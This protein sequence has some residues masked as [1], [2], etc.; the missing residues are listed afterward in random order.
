MI[1]NTD[2]LEFIGISVSNFRQFKNN[3]MGWKNSIIYHSGRASRLIQRI[4]G[5]TEYADL[6]AEAE[7]DYT[8]YS[9]DMREAELNLVA[10]YISKARGN[11]D[12]DGTVS[13]SIQGRVTITKDL[14]EVRTMDYYLQAMAILARQGYSPLSIKR[15]EYDSLGRPI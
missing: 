11:Y 3:L 2:N 12:D 6:E 15:L 1:C 10:F 13:Q 8:M 9:N 4:V 14:Q 5:E 7:A